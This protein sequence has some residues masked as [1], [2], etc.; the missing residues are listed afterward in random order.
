[1]SKKRRG[2]VGTLV[3]ENQ[4][5]KARSAECEDRYLRAVAE[6]DNQ[7]RRLQREAELQ[8]RLVK[9]D[10]LGQLL[11]VLDNFGR[12]MQAA[13]RPDANGESLAKGIELIHRQLVDVLAG[14]GLESYSCLGEEFDPQRAEATGFVHCDGPDRANRVVEEQCRGYAC[15][16]R[17]LRPARVVVAKEVP[18]VGAESGSSEAGGSKDGE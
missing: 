2:P 4:S 12:A 17:V 10:V 14:L 15:D 7:R 1:M 11:D 6:F 16:G 8:R 18:A 3:E 13:A 5:L 9:E